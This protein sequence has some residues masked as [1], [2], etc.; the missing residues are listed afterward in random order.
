MTAQQ[1]IDLIGRDRISLALG[2][3]KGAISAAYVKDEMPAAWF[4]VISRLMREH[5]HDTPRGA[6]SF[7][8]MAE[9]EA[10]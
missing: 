6:F 5:G 10:A 1:I 7:K 9:G 2:V 3:K 4:D 8:P